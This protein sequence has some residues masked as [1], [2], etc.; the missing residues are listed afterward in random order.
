MSEYRYLFGPVP[1]RRFGRSLGIDLV[2]MKTCTLDC[3]FCQLGRSPVTTIDRREYVPTEEVM[4]ELRDWLEVDGA[5]DYLTLSGSGEPTLHTKFGDVLEFLESHSSVPRLLMTNG[6]LLHLP[7]VR[8]SACSASVVKMS[9]SA[10]DQE[11]FERINRGARGI[12]FDMLVAGEKAFRR[13]FA[14]KI[15]LEVFVVQGV[16]SAP[17]NVEKIARLAEDIGPDNIQ[18][19]TAVRPPAEMSAVAP[20]RECL[21]ELASLF[22]PPA[23]II[24]AYGREVAGGGEVDAERVLAVLRRRPCTAKQIAGGL[25]IH[26]SEAS[27]HLGVLLQHNLISPRQTGE[28]TYYAVR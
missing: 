12:T 7:E 8:R 20:P 9:L 26:V 11:S 25:G 27:K 13:E 3:L 21:E 24:A 10:W 2:P 18:I 17:A 14:G 19:N 6:T 23:E 22:S 1:S 28:E 5:A 16:N 4:A 15:W